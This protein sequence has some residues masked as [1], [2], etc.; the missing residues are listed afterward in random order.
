MSQKQFCWDANSSFPIRI[1]IREI[2]CNWIYCMCRHVMPSWI[3]H[4][5]SLKIKVST[6]AFT[7]WHRELKYIFP[8]CVLD[9]N[10]TQHGRCDC[11][12]RIMTVICIFVA[13]EFAGIQV[14]IQFG[15]YNE[16]KHKAGFLEWVFAF[17]FF[18]K[19][20]CVLNAKTLFIFIS[21]W[22][23]FCLRGTLALKTLKRN[24]SKSIVDTLV[25]P[26][27]MLKLNTRKR[28]ANCQRTASHFS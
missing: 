11:Y 6:S 16:Q 28:H 26:K 12:W 8:F 13:C 2:R 23:S 20:Y 22:K 14:H 10:A 9:I 25:S 5:Q 17:P 15:D 3:A 21:A 7:V 19:Y 4:I 27:S 1:S 24:Y 18:N